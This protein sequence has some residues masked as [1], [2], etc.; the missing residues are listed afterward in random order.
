MNLFQVIKCS[1]CPRRF[2]SYI[3]YECKQTISDHCD[4]C[5]ARTLH[6]GVRY[7]R[8]GM[9]CPHCGQITQ[10]PRYRQTRVWILHNLAHWSEDEIVQQL[11][12]KNKTVKYH[13]KWMIT[14]CEHCHE[15]ILP[16][17]VILEIFWLYKCHLGFTQAEV[18]KMLGKSITTVKRAITSCE[19]RYGLIIRDLNLYTVK[20]R[21]IPM[22]KLA[23]L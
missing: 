8:L 2:H 15:R 13:L 19:T 17:L 22:G 18:A 11:R 14:L 9:Y 21:I 23:D 3:C 6:R 1:L 7:L 5:H 4:K 16:P 10:K 12:I 20:P